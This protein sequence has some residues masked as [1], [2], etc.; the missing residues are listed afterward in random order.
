MDIEKLK[1]EHNGI[2]VGSPLEMLSTAATAILNSNLN[3]VV[4]PVIDSSVNSVVNPVVNSGENL[5]AF[6]VHYI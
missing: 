5:F 6:K 1:D 4:N 3:P 2:E